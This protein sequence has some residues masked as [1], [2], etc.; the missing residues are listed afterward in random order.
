[1]NVH[2]RFR[3]LCINVGVLFS[4]L[5]ICFL[6]IEIGLRIIYGNPHIFRSPQV[7]HIPTPYGYKPE[8]NQHGSYTLN[9]L[10]TV[11]SSGFRDTREWIVPKPTGSYRIIIVGDSFT[12]GNGVNTEERFS[13]LLDKY[14]QKNHGQV[15]V[16]NASAGGWNLNN[17]FFFFNTEGLSYEPDALVLA[18]FPNDWMSPPS[19][20]MPD[21]VPIANLSQEGRWDARPYWLR[22]LPYEWIYKLKYSATVIYLRDRLFLIGAKPDIVTRLLQDQVD[23]DREPTIAYSYQK[24]GEMKQTCDVKGIPMVIAVIPPVNFFWLSDGSPSYIE[25]F[26]KF[27]ESRGIVFVDLSI[28]LRMTRAQNLY[29][30]YPWDNHLNP[31]GH[32]R[33]ADQL[34]P[35]IEQ[36]IM[37]LVRGK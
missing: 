6:L 25:H 10:V 8:P 17:E 12:F 5:L 24:L 11:N 19:P 23:L 13:N 2:Y 37:P 14:L 36:L 31:V 22:W 35:V 34:I 3:N 20:S 26:R 16:L 15:E 9:K 30:N 1:M 7:R 33:V 4:S 32:K 29:Y 18:F 27:A 28:G 21:P